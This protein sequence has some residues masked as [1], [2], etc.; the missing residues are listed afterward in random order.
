MSEP[1]PGLTAMASGMTLVSSVLKSPKGEMARGR[2]TVRYFGVLSSHGTDSPR[3]WRRLPSPSGHR[4]TGRRGAGDAPSGSGSR[5]KK[6]PSIDLGAAARNASLRQALAVVGRH[7][8]DEDAHDLSK[9]FP[10]EG[11]RKSQ[12]ERHRQQSSS[13]SAPWSAPAR[14]RRCAHEGVAVGNGRRVA[15]EDHPPSRIRAAEKEPARE[16]A[17]DRSLRR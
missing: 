16:R 7:R 10:G 8:V 12:R 14:S 3:P 17:M 13:A 6:P 2:H 9:E 1:P 5:T 15:P 4:R 11:Q